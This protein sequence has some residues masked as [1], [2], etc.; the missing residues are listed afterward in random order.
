M[1]ELEIDEVM[2]LTMKKGYPVDGEMARN[3]GA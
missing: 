1:R 2:M 3:G